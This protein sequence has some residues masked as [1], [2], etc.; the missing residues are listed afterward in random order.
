MWTKLHPVFFVFQFTATS[1]G[2]RSFPPAPTGVRVN[3]T[4]YSI[5]IEWDLYPSPYDPIFY[6]RL[7]SPGKSDL[8]GTER[9]S[10]S[11]LETLLLV[12]NPCNT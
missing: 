9:A 12:Y 5:D 1:L 4:S 3:T 6:I 2:R 11:W 8:S 10:R 7:E